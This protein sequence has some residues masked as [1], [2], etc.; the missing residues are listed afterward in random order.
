MYIVCTIQGNELHFLTV[1]IH[2]LSRAQP[3]ISLS[4]FTY[5]LVIAL[6]HKS[7]DKL[8]V[9]KSVVLLLSFYC[10]L[11][12]VLHLGCFVRD[13][14]QLCHSP[15]KCREFVCVEI[16]LPLIIICSRTNTD[17]APRHCRM[18]VLRLVGSDGKGL[19]VKSVIVQLVF[20][21][22]L[23]VQSSSSSSALSSCRME[24]HVNSS[25]LQNANRN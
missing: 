21:Q 13:Q 5:F 20:W 11:N 16:A 9:M 14:I 23:K 15:K 7:V 24:N 8:N 12:K 2:S 10:M 22:V 3:K 4:H 1:I 6:V 17:C 19:E 18:C 25:W